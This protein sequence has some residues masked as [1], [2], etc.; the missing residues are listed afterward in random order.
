MTVESQEDVDLPTVIL[1]YAGKI[2]DEIVKFL[3]EFETEL[4]IEL[5][6]NP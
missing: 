4:K 6:R 1:V 2:H 3:E 5:L